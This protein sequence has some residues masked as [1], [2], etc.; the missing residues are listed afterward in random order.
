M[1]D[2]NNSQNKH[3]LLH[4]SVECCGRSALAGLATFWFGTF[5][6]NVFSYYKKILNKKIIVYF[7]QFSRHHILYNNYYANVLVIH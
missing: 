7:L 4:P 1:N 3:F 5:F 6:E 2:A